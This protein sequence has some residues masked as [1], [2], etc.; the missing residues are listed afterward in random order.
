M[1]QLASR[2]RLA[3]PGRLCTPFPS[4]SIIG[5][6]LARIKQAKES[7]KGAK[8]GVYYGLCVLAVL[9]EAFVGR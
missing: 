6:R 3:T 1:L 2:K 7:R 4:V 5:P 9:R 8:E